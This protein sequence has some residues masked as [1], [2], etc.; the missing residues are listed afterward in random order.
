MSAAEEIKIETDFTLL[1]FQNDTDETQR[2]EK[3]VKTGLI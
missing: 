3:Q 2:F 1:R